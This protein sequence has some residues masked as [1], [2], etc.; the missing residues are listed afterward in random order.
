MSDKTS[1]TPWWKPVAHFAAHTT[2][3]TVLF[4][5]IA[6]PAVAL[7]LLV[8]WLAGLHVGAFIITVLT[9]LEDA[10]LLIDALLYLVY[11]GV[12]AKRAIKEMCEDEDISD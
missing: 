9:F 10:I 1:K 4:G 7:N 3:G 5:I 6:I 12:T 8:A 2:I 11:L